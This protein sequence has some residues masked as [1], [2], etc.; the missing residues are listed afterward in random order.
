MDASRT[1]NVAVNHDIFRPT[2]SSELF[3]DPSNEFVLHITLVD[4]EESSVRAHTIY[5]SPLPIC[6]YIWHWR[7]YK[8]KL[9]LHL[10]W[11]QEMRDEST[12]AR[13]EDWGTY[14]MY[15]SSTCTKY[16]LSV[17]NVQ[18]TVQTRNILL[19][20]DKILD[21][22]FQINVNLTWLDINRILHSSYK[23]FKS[24]Q[25]HFISTGWPDGP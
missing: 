19:I 9:Q 11:D 21:Q 1:L 4:P 18:K 10:R 25:N 3:V 20:I 7:S 23:Y 22:R 2:I 24:F 16:T 17:C 14:G 12:A 6:Y 13:T 15:S 8:S 5:Y